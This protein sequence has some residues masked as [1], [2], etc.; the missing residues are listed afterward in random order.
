MSRIV[1]IDRDGTIIEEPADYQID[2]YAKL[3]FVEGVIPALLSLRDAG[4]EFVMV[5]N[6]DGLGTDSYP[7][8]TFQGPHD[9][10]MQVLESQGIRFRE[11][12]IDRHFAHENHPDRKPNLGLVMGYLR[13]RSVDL[14]GSAMVGDRETDMQFARN[15]GVRGFK[16]RVTA[17]AQA[18]GASD[19]ERLYGWA[20]IAHLLVNA[21]RQARVERLTKETRI[22]VDVDLDRVAEPVVMTGLGYFD[23]MLEQIGKHGGFTLRLRC[24]GDLH[25]D[26]HHTVEDC[27]LALGQALRQALGDK[28]G[29]GRYASAQ[30]RKSVV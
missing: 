3:R 6:Q 2:S 12:L 4:F 23:H 7:L 22:E 8:E 19:G 20:E 17:G 27:A 24:A 26:E 5:S 9:L 29:I 16:L 21:P 14:A 25:I 28:R 10:M 11:V 13:D 18:D 30:D 15:L 1:F